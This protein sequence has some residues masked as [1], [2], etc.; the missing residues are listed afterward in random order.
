MRHCGNW[1]CPRPMSRARRGSGWSRSTMSVDDRPAAQRSPSI[2]DQVL[3]VSAAV[4]RVPS[5]AVTP[6]TTP[7]G[8]AAWDSVAHLTLIL[9]LEQEF[10]ITIAPEDSDGMGS[11]EKVAMVVERAIASRDGP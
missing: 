1:I 2:V 9:A 6:Q 10:A 4:F 8:L 7:G 3:A 5:N 11:L